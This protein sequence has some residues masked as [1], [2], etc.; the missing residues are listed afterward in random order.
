[1]YIYMCMYIYVIYIY[2]NISIIYTHSSYVSAHTNTS[3]NRQKRSGTRNV[4][5]LNVPFKAI[6]HITT[7]CTQ[8]TAHNEIYPHTHV[9]ARTHTHTYTH[10]N[11]NPCCVPL[12]VTEY[13]ST[14]THHSSL[15]PK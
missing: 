11:C 15:N 4:S 13:A 10:L 3:K 12:K 5:E 9:Y 8:C 6:E 2:E 14:R 7:T 1:M